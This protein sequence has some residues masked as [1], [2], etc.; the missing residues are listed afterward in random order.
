MGKN[1]SAV[2]ETLVHPLGREDSSGEGNGNT[3]Q[4]SG[5]ENSHEQ[6][7]LVGY[8]PWGHKELDIIEKLTHNPKDHNFTNLSD[9][10]M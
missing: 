6:R 5:P 10:P 9:M 2:Q 3:L 8:S 7:I 1:L 4:Y